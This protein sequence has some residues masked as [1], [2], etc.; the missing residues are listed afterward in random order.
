MIMGG[1]PIPKYEYSFA[2]GH[3]TTPGMGYIIHTLGRVES[4]QG[5]SGEGLI[6]E[7][8]ELCN[9]FMRIYN[10]QEHAEGIFDPA[11]NRILD[12]NGVECLF[13]PLFLCGEGRIRSARGAGGVCGG[14]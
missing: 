11:F 8:Y 2:H 10:I 9:F 5:A 7:K 1:N 12:F 6:G 3:Y 13:R 14:W 4:G